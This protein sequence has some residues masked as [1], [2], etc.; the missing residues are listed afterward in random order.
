MGGLS[1]GSRRALGQN[2]AS[3]GA[4]ALVRVLRPLQLAPCNGP[5]SVHMYTVQH[6]IS[7]SEFSCTELVVRITNA[8]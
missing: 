5:V 7:L 8:M 2:S 1:T 6:R 4:D 3:V